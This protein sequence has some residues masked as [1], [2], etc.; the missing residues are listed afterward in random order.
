MSGDWLKVLN[1]RANRAAVLATALAGLAACGTDTADR[2]Q[3][4][5]ATGA[6]SGAAIGAIAGPF[7]IVGGALIG[8]G[9]GALTGVTTSP[10]QVNLGAPPWSDK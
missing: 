7:G 6:A 2:A 5:A 10:S 4:G 9:A 1:R 3:G 8:G